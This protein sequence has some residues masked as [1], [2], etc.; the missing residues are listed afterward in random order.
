VISSI[1]VKD[2]IWRVGVLLS[3]VAPQYTRWSEAEI[4]NYVNDGQLAIV[5]FLPAACARID[6]IKLKPGTRQSIEQ[7]AAADC[8]PGD[9]S[10]P[11]APIL[12]TQ[13]LDVIR[14]MGADGL[15]PGNPVRLIPDGR[16]TLDVTSPSW[17]TVTSQQVAHY[18]FDP[19]APTHFYVSPGVPA[20]PAVWAELMFAAQPLK[21]PPGGVPGSPVYAI[22]GASALKLSVSDENVDDLVNYVVARCYMKQSNAGSQ[23]RAAH[24]T[25]LF[26][27]SLNARVLA[28][29][30][31]N[32]NLKR[33]PF[34]QTPIG[35]AS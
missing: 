1:T 17:H 29:T 35:Q 30:G 6:A 15:T 5:K 4:V 34:A 20:S 31:N 3:D 13:L 19:R 24:F 21:V 33:L 22:D 11:A 12:G 32:P 9:G 10:T 14:N 18:I 7:I 2:C 16:E 26:T 23:D 28:L 8:K 27:G 25:G